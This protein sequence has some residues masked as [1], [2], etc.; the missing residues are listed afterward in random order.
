MCDR[1]QPAPKGCSDGRKCATQKPSSPAGS[2]TMYRIRG[3]RANEGCSNAR[4]RIGA[5]RTNDS[6]PTRF[7]TTEAPIEHDVPGP[8]PKFAR[9]P[10]MR[11]RP[12]SLA[13][14]ERV[15]CVRSAYLHSRKRYK[16]SVLGSD[17]AMVQR[18]GGS[19]P[20]LIH[21]TVRIRMRFDRHSG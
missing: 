17:A 21:E 11:G 4:K 6:C 15:R 12:S 3:T 14:T 7:V 9:I 1:F 8:M 20:C 18:K 2:V 5:V 16:P 10:N 19:F 13:I